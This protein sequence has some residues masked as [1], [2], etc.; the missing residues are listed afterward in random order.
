M[1]TANVYEPRNPLDAYPRPPFPAKK[2]SGSGDTDE[3]DPRPDHGES[4]YIGHGR[5]PGRKALITG[6]DSGIGRAVAIAF[7]REGADI[8]IGYHESPDDAEATASLVRAAG[9]EAILLQGDIAQEDDCVDLVER[10]VAGLG[11]IDLLVMVAGAQ[12]TIDSIDDLETEDLDRMMK[13]NVYSL[14]WLT[15]AAVAHFSPGAAIIT[16]SSIQAFHPSPEL[17]E[18]ATTKAAIANF[19]RAMAQQLAGRGIRVN[20]VAPGPF[21]T[22]LQPATAPEGK[23]EHFGEQVP[24]GRPGQPA[25]LA[26]TYVYL[27]SQESSYTSGE[28]VLVNGGEPGH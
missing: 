23:L 3:M 4:S 14:F 22:P 7:A 1:T 5:L 16:T 24:Y 26:S 17:A 6:A 13:T 9:R 8:A 18:Y 28:T 27:A 19:T 25:E 11:G 15:K 21:W 20:G 10:T 12:S 2:Q